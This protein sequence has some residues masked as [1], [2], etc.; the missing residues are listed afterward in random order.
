LG[1]VVARPRD[2][3]EHLDV[4][5]TLSASLAAITPRRRRLLVRATGARFTNQLAF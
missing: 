1:E 2:R 4:E 3:L 5:R